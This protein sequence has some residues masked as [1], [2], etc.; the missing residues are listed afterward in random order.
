MSQQRKTETKDWIKQ[1]FAQL[2]TQF[3]LDKISVQQLVDKAGISRGTFYLHYQDK[4]D[5]NQQLHD[6]T[7]EQFQLLLEKIQKQGVSALLSMLL[8][9]QQDKEFYQALYQAH[10]I[11]LAL[12]IQNFIDQALGDKLPIRQDLNL[13][14][15]YCHQITRASIQALI[16]HWIDQNCQEEPE[17][18]YQALLHLGGWNDNPSMQRKGGVQNWFLINKP[19]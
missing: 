15:D 10:S 2:I 13:P 17:R 12:A 14:A 6:E 4:Y 7:L 1:A 9:I 8:L 16:L 18:I 5:L 3:P 11:D 19:S